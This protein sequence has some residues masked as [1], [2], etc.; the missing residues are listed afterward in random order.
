MLTFEGLKNSQD[1]FRV[2]SHSNEEFLT[3]IP[4]IPDNRNSCKKF[5]QTNG[6]EGWEMITF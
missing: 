1:V 5:P 3:G 6:P 4:E 2:L